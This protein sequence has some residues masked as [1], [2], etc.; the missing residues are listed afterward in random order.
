[1]CAWSARARVRARVHTNK[2]MRVCEETKK[3]RS[4]Q[5]FANAAS[6]YVCVYACLR[7][8]VCMSGGRRA[9]PSRG[10]KQ[11]G[12]Q[13][14]PQRKKKS[15]GFRRTRTPRVKVTWGF[16]PSAQCD[17]GPILLHTHA[18][19]PASAPRVSGGRR[20]GD[21]WERGGHTYTHTHTHIHTHTPP[22]A[23]QG[24]RCSK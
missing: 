2:C 16:N 8:Y 17:P 6:M 4:T 13:P 1:V 22:A 20:A 10:G 21:A 15:T 14:T 18:P 12:G 3:K 19:L 7:T 23:E 11:S 5:T 24:G 9:G